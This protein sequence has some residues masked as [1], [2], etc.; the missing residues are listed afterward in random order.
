MTVH[1]RLLL[2]HLAYT[3]KRPPGVI[4]YFSEKKGRGKECDRARSLRVLSRRFSGY[5]EC[6]KQSYVWLQI[7]TYAFTQHFSGLRSLGSH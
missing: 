3:T 5:V 7:S 6:Y 4:Q 2:Y 1:S